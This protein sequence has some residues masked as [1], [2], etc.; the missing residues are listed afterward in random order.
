MILMFLGG[1]GWESMFTTQVSLSY[2]DNFPYG[3]KKDWNEMTKS[4]SLFTIVWTY[5]LLVDNSL[6][7]LMLII[8]YSKAIERLILEVWSGNNIPSLPNNPNK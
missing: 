5:I 8:T 3:T 1:L 2:Y 7:L 4:Y 6:N